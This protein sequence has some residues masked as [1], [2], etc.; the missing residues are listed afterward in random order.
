MGI[1]REGYSMDLAWGG[2]AESGAA[3]APGSCAL[4]GEGDDGAE[5]RGGRSCRQ[6]LLGAGPVPLWH[7]GRRGAGNELGSRAC[8]KGVRK[9]F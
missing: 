4:W 1:N 2:G 9:V 8:G 3:L 7:L 6:V 5:P